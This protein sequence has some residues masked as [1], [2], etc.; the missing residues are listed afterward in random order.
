MVLPGLKQL[1]CCV[2]WGC[3]LT[4]AWVRVCQ[5]AFRHESTEAENMLWINTKRADKYS[6]KK[7]KKD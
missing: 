5:C 4:P 6:L 1:I 7:K 3:T 2:Y